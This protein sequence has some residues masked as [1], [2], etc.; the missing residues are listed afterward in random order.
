MMNRLAATGATLVV[1][2]VPDVTAVAFLTS[3]EQ[4]AEVVGLP[5][6]VI[7]PPL[8][9]APGDFVTPDAFPLIGAILTGQIAGPLPGNV[10]LTAAEVATIRA[11]TASFNSIIAAQAAAHGAA[12]V[13]AHALL[14][15][16]QAR[17]LVVNGQRLTTEFL[18]GL[19]SLDGIHP[20]NTGYALVANEFIHTL[21]ARFAAGIPP[22]AL[23]HVAMDDALVFAAVGRP[24]S[25]L[26]RIGAATTQAMRAIFAH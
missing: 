8:G 2:N 16:L 26:G 10:V 22:L 17:G 5:L 13:D 23:E 18:G 4:V 11:A 12:L 3:A 24:A 6:G 20:T 21:N 19:F 9:I 15:T 1:A 14:S 25:A 7:G